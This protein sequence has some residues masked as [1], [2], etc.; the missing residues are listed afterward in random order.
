MPIFVRKYI[1]E[2]YY[3]K[4]IMFKLVPLFKAESYVTM[5]NFGKFIFNSMKLRSSYTLTWQYVRTRSPKNGPL[6]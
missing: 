1:K 3:K 4:P 5:F 2:Y 6:S